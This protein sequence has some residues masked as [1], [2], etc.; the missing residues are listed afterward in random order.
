MKN[1]LFK[2]AAVLSAVILTLSCAKIVEEASLAGSAG[3]AASAKIINNPSGADAA[4]LL[5][6]AEGVST[7]TLDS[8]CRECGA[9]SCEPLFQSI[10]G[11]EELERK[12]GM[13]NWYKLSFAS[14]TDIQGKAM[15][16]ASCGGVNTVEYNKKMKKCN[17]GKPRPYV[18]TRSGGVTLSGASAPKFNDPSLAQ[19]WHY[20]NDGKSYKSGGKVIKEAYE[21]ADV[22]VSRAWNLCAGNPEVIVA[23]IDEA[24]QYNHPDIEANIWNNPQSGTKRG[25]Y[26]GDKHGWNFVRNSA[27]LNW[28]DFGNSGHGTHVAGTVAAV[29]NNGTGVCGLAGGSGNNDGVKLMSCQIFDGF[30]GGTSDVIANAFK[31]AA[32]NG[33]CIAQCSF[34]V[35]SGDYKSDDKYYEASSAEVLAM[36]YFIEK[37]NCQA[38]DGGLIIVAAGNDGL[39][40]SSYPAALRE[41][42]SVCAIG[43]DG[44]PVYY[45]NYG[46]GCNISAPGGEPY[47]GGQ[48]RDECQVLSTMPT[49]KIEDY[50][51]EEDD[52]NFERPIPSGE[53]LPTDYGWMSGTSMACPHASGVA[54]LGLS[55]ALKKG[56]HYTNEEF[57]SL[58][59]TSV[60]GIDAHITS[61]DS[62]QTIVD[63]GF[64]GP[65]YGPMK[66]SKFK[67]NMGTG[68]PDVWRLYMNMDGTPTLLASTGEAQ[69]IDVS[70]YF[71]TS[72]E[73]LTYLS[74]ELLD[75]AMDVL[76][77]SEKPMM[78]FG[79]LQIHPT[80]AGCAR[81]KIKAI[82]GG[83]KVATGSQMGGTEVSRVVSIISKP[84]LS[85]NGGW[86]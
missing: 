46:P 22:N 24:V 10:P 69:K 11:N 77:L 84:G 61:A 27:E 33:A 42:I 23:V 40:P 44:L 67:N 62:K 64:L 13:H 63:V 59:M 35:E 16:L 76:G 54:A 9:Q 39:S 19:Q 86:L 74:V 2:L 38:L 31:Y 17:V 80:K 34:G 15:K 41:C 51:Y 70:G 7:E 83:N 43:I 85:S 53:Y 5:F 56:Y 21:G 6:C 4:S 78:R 18:V 52:E 82:A 14:A 3:N 73:N 12:F 49:D 36:R 45:T 37:S 32:D 79:K 57:K 66:L 71:G 58:L 81:L 65:I 25:I 72:S 28:A 75:D 26:V 48:D 50:Y 55:Y 68:V 8:L 47:T 30:N 1:K 60:Y 29:N 20:Y